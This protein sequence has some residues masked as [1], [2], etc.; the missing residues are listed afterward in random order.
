MCAGAAH[1]LSQQAILFF[2]V[3]SWSWAVATTKK[4]IGLFF[5]NV[6]VSPFY[7]FPLFSALIAQA[8]LEDEALVAAP[9][10]AR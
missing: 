4:S 1:T 10:G 2:Q 3:M 5:V 6:G 8:R 7:F 9:V